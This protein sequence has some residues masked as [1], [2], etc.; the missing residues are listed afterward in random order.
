MEQFITV[1]LYS[2]DASQ[3]YFTFYYMTWSGIAVQHT[4]YG[5]SRCVNF[6]GVLVRNMVFMYLPDGT[7]VNG[8]RQGEFDGIRSV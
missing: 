3:D 4:D 7:N 2:Q 1:E 5:C 8:S 6:G